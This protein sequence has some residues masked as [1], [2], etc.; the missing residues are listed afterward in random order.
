MKLLLADN[1]ELDIGQFLLDFLLK[2][3]RFQQWYIFF[4]I[5]MNSYGMF[6]VKIGFTLRSVYSFVIGMN[7]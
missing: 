5:G 1:V 4:V 6:L 3:H 7:L 2:P